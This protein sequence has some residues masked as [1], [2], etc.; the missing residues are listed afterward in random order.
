MKDIKIKQVN[1]KLI[2]GIMA[3]MITVT[4]VGCD[5]GSLKSCN[6][7]SIEICNEKVSIKKILVLTSDDQVLFV[8]YDNKDDEHVTDIFTNTKY[9]IYNG[10][11]FDRFSKIITVKSG[12][13]NS[14]FIYDIEYKIQTM[15]DYIAS[16]T[17][18]PNKY[19]SYEELKQLF[20]ELNNINSTV[21]SNT[22]S[23]LISLE[24]VVAFT[25][26]GETLFVKYENKTD[27]YVTNIFEKKNYYV[28]ESYANINARLSSGVYYAND[29]YYDVK[30][31]TLYPF[32][33]E[34]AVDGKIPKSILKESLNESNKDNKVLQKSNK[35][36]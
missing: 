16:I 11:F 2:A 9:T 27:K 25:K 14:V 15:N 26:D 32:I 22:D 24:N 6:T 4:L 13:K 3:G 36:N 21:N 18:N 10:M 34:N 23:E 19:N 29:K 33:V 20:M 35:N 1:K 28:D 5:I 31:I 12:M 30:S 7:T 8:K 17:N